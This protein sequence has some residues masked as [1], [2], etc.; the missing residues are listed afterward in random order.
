[1]DVDVAA[2][3]LHAVVPMLT[4]LFF[5]TI[6]SNPVPVILILVGILVSMLVTTGVAELNHSKLQFAEHFVGMPFIL[7]EN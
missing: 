3:T 1:M 2:V 6:P 7:I 5:I 4:I